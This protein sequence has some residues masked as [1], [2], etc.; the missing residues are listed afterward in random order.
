MIK[1]PENLD[2]FTEKLLA[3]AETVEGFL[4]HN[5]MR[6]LTMVAA[7]P[8]AQGD[9]LEIGSF[10]GKS[11]VVLAK[12]A[13]LAGDERIYAVDPLTAP[14]ETDPDLRGDESS[15]KDFKANIERCGIADAIEFHQMFSY[16]LAE[17]WTR[18]LR[19]L[20]IDGDHT[21]KG[22]KRDFD[23]FAP[24]LNDG[25]IIAIH[26]V[27]HA[28]DGGV[29]VFMEDILL[30]PNFGACGFCGSIG[31]AQYRED[32]TKAVKFRSEKLS[33]YTKLS[34]L[35]P[36][37]VFNKQLHGLEKKIYKL[38]RSRVPRSLIKPAEWLKMVS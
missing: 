4:S 21:Y 5:E 7:C 28:F 31:W 12:A 1:L 20:W 9:V 36:H 29:R 35:I 32:E 19:L 24:F 30:S 37:I 2:S 17:E 27:L 33:L 13:Q 16:Q 10:K 8:T 23:G 22:T 14:C 38:K 34:R 25:G 26:D 3:E 15:L 6:F 11:T 18:P